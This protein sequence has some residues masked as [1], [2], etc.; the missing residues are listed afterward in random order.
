[1]GAGV[2]DA[3]VVDLSAPSDVGSE[4]DDVVGFASD[5]TVAATV[6][7]AEAVFDATGAAASKKAG[8]AGLPAPFALACAAVCFADVAMT[9]AVA[10]CAV[11]LAVTAASAVIPVGAVAPAVGPDVVAANVSAE[12]SL[13]CVAAPGAAVLAAMAAAAMV[14]G[15]ELAGAEAVTATLAGVAVTGIATA[16]AFS[17]VTAVAP[18]CGAAADGSVDEAPLDASLAV[19]F[20]FPALVASDL[21]TDREPDGCDAS[22][23]ALE[24]A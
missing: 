18:S 5:A 13:S 24:L 1:L 17:G 6:A 10:P 19:D 11:A 2:A 9:S 16:I 4:A 7:L 20:E 23:L 12:P 15:V 14:S 3:V 22:V 21:V 8:N